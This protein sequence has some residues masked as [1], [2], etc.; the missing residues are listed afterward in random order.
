MVTLEAEVLPTVGL[1]PDIA[2]FNSV[3]QAQDLFEKSEGGCFL[4]AIDWFDSRF[5]A[6]GQSLFWS[7]ASDLRARPCC[8]ICLGKVARVNPALRHIMT[9][10]TMPEMQNRTHI[11]FASLVGLQQQKSHTHTHT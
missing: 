10:S 1:R 4:A 5:L 2:T 3:P 9:Y 7:K 6:C 8:I 11:N